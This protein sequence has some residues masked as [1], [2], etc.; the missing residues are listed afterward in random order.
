MKIVFAIGMSS[1]F[2]TM[3]VQTKT[4]NSC[5]M[6]ASITFSSSASGICP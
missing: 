6:N 4:S 5:R 1:P 3:V 2:S